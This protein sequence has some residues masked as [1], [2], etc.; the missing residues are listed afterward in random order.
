MIKPSQISIKE[1]TPQKAG[2]YKFSCWMGMVTGVIEVV[3]TNNSSLNS[4]AQ[5]ALIQNEEEL[6]L[7]SGASGCGCGQKNN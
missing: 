5:A 1:F 4:S 2:K 7:P 6:T 3:D